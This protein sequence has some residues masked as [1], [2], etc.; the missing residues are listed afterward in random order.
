MPRP[1]DGEF[2][3]QVWAKDPTYVNHRRR[4]LQPR[5]IPG[6]CLW[7]WPKTGQ[8]LVAIG[9]SEVVRTRTIQRRPEAERWSPHTISTLQSTPQKWD[10]P[11]DVTP[12]GNA[13]NAEELDT[14]ESFEAEVH[15][16]PGPSKGHRAGRASHQQSA[17]TL[18]L[19]LLSRVAN[20][21]LLVRQTFHTAKSA[22]T[23][24][25]KSCKAFSEQ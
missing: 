4:S 23:V 14:R 12:V 19:R 13:V 18:A 8:N 5:A 1:I 24:S 17:E 6:T 11:G 25:L 20:E 3:E 15:A 7:L 16:A 21:D 22:G 9:P 10:T 2:G